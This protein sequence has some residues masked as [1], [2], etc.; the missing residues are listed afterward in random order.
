MVTGSGIVSL[1]FGLFICYHIGFVDGLFAAHPH[2]TP[3]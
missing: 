1:A 3:S 2:W